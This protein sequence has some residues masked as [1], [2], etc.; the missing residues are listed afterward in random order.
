MK[1]NIRGMAMVTI[2]LVSAALLAI[3]SAGLGMGSSSVL[4]VSQAHQRNVALAAAESGVYEAMLRL[5]QDKA[6]FGS[7]S[8]VLAESDGAYRFTVENNLLSQ[9]LAVIT[10]TGSTGDVER[11]LRVTVEPDASS[12]AGLAVE[13]KVYVFDVAYV[14][15]IASAANPLVRPGNAHTNFS[16]SDSAFLAKDYNDDGAPTILRTTGELSASGSFDSD[17]NTVQVNRSTGVN[18]SLY[19][20]DRAAMLSGSFT[21]ASGP[22]SPSI[23][24]NTRY[25]GDTTF[26]Q[27]IRVA[28]GVTLHITGEAEFLGGLAGEGNVVVEG[29][30][31]VRT[32]SSFDPNIE[33]GIKLLSDAS[34]FIV[35]PSSEVSSSDV[36]IQFDDVG[37]YFAQMPREAYSEI[38][39]GI[40]VSAPKGSDFFGWY[41][42]NAGSTSQDFQS[43]YNGDGSKIYPGLSQP[44]KDWLNLSIGK[45]AAIQAWAAAH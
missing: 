9:N 25:S 29:D 21:N 18:K 39:N 37:D 20:L 35:H 19:R 6:F 4:M 38:A 13:G 7:D 2:L 44:T 30:T 1:K 28:K 11:T 17:L 40:P 3:I 22:G 33:G 24:T 43:W 36:S 14:N 16:G 45:A 34:I 41:A 32:D 31:V 12:F 26:V 42:A 8:A 5:E 10:S 15:A 23:T 27:K